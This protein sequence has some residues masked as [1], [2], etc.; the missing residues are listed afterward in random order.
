MKKQYKVMA[1]TLA[2]CSMLAACSTKDDKKDNK[3]ENKVENKAN[4]AKDHAEDSI[5]NMMSYFKEKGVTY[6][7]SENIDQMDFAAYEGR[8][9]MANNNRVYLYRVK[10]EDENMKKILKE[11]ADK[12]K[13]KVRI[14]NKESEY[15][16][17][18][19]GDYL[20]LYD[21]NADITDVLGAFPGYRAG[22]TTT[23][24][25]TDE[26]DQSN[27]QSNTQDSTENQSTTNEG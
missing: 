8:S 22:T 15:N 5:D 7:Q 14:D 2:L 23:T 19:N 11:A 18:V 6:D 17:K 20:L 9:F 12:G 16:A 25:S 13:V 26:S 1:C 3:T 10:S 24:T 21:T 4:T 27:D